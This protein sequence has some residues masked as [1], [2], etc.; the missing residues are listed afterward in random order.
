LLGAGCLV[1]GIR[2]HI[3]QST[4]EKF[5]LTVAV[6]TFV[7]LTLISSK[8]EIYM[9]PAIP[10]F[11]YFTALVLPKMIDSKIVKLSLFI[12][13]VIFALAFPAFIVADNRGLLDI[14]LQ[15]LTIAAVIASV[16][17]ELSLVTLFCNNISYSIGSLFCGLFVAAFC[18]GLKM[19]VLNRY[20]GYRH[21]CQR[22]QQIAEE[23]NLSD[24]Y[25]YK[26]DRPNDIDVYT[27][28]PVMI[29]KEGEE[30]RFNKRGVVIIPQ[31]E[32]C[33]KKYYESIRFEDT[34]Y[35]ILVYPKQRRRLDS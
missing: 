26:L 3:I 32:S 21:V 5:F 18:I 29:I 28:Q 19:P 31:M 6:S 10:F 35:T 14:P 13:A 1:E 8:L 11:V 24:I 9:L 25:V 15:P 17:G 30:S 33:G 34:P 7:L 22:A 23:Y 16:A 27:R 4:E 12:P 20:V 2:R